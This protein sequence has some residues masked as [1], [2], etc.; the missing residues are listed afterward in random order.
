MESLSNWQLAL[1]AIASVPLCY[2]YRPRESVVI[3]CLRLEERAAQLGPKA[4]IDLDCVLDGGGELHRILDV[5]ARHDCDGAVV[6]LHSDDLDDDVLR[7]AMCRLTECWPFELHAGYY[8]VREDSISG[9]TAD[10]EFLGT[11]TDLELLTTQVAMRTPARDVLEGP[12]GFR[13]P[14]S[15][16][17]T[18]ATRVADSYAR[19]KDAAPSWR[20]LTRHCTDALR[21][22]RQLSP[23]VAGRLL[24]GFEDNRFRDGFLAWAVGGAG[25]QVR[26]LRTVDPGMAFGDIEPDAPRLEAALGL[27]ARVAAV[28]PPSGAALPIAMSAFLAWYGGDGTRAR[29]LAEQAQEEREG[30]HLTEL[31][32]EAL[33]R[34]LPPPWFEGVAGYCRARPGGGPWS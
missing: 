11:V 20:D 1:E 30:L 15:P 18:P 9:W 6:S 3:S 25:R 2:G 27:L 21:T 10:G 19:C 22:A 34:A 4:R 14:R 33:G 16:G 5:L 28:A 26:D 29:V 23:D 17:G 31:V 24:W 13:L 7:S 12:E 8:V 32:L